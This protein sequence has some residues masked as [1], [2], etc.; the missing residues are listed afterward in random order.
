[1]LP[2][3]L[4]ESFRFGVGQAGGAMPAAAEDLVAAHDQGTHGGIGA[5]AADPAGGFREG[6]AHSLFVVHG[7]QA[8]STHAMFP[9]EASLRPEEDWRWLVF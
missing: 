6:Q 5:G 8:V 4:G 1:V 2:D 7:R 9:G 3:R